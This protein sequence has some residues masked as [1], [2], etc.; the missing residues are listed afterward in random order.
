MF[1]PEV[2]VRRWRHRWRPEHRNWHGSRRRHRRDGVTELLIPDG[3][4]DDERS[5]GEGSETQREADYHTARSANSCPGTGDRRASSASDH[6]TEGHLGDAPAAGIAVNDRV[7]VG[8]D[9]GGS[10]RVSPRQRLRIRRQEPAL[11]LRRVSSSA[12]LSSAIVVV[13]RVVGCYSNDARMTRWPLP[14]SASSAATPTLGTRPRPC[15]HHFSRQC[16]A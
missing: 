9:I 4:V 11:A 15:A 16:R 5:S 1:R 2:V 14:L 6:R 10:A 7:A 12:M 13:L 3:F 8:V